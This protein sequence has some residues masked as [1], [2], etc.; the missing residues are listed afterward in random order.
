[1]KLFQFVTI[2]FSSLFLFIFV[3]CFYRVNS[4]LPY[5]SFYDVLTYISTL[6]NNIWGDFLSALNNFRNAYIDIPNV[7]FNV[8]NAI[9]LLKYIGVLLLNIY[10]YFSNL[11]IAQFVFIRDFATFVF[12]ILKI[13][14]DL[15]SFLFS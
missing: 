6:T 15:L 3:V 7:D 10:K 5:L 4:D 1:M 13:F 12:N 8:N 14:T 9:D 11:F 2:I